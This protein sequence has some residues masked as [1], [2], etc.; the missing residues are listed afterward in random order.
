M[1]LEETGLNCGDQT[2]LAKNR[3]R[4]RAFLNKAIKLWVP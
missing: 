3:D 4:L 1:N 2:H